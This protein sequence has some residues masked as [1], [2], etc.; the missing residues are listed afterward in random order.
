MSKTLYQEFLVVGI[1]PETDAAAYAEQQGMRI[2]H[3]IAKHIAIAALS[4]GRV[5]P[6]FN[7]TAAVYAP[8]DDRSI[9]V[10]SYEPEHLAAIMRWRQA[11]RTQ[12]IG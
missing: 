4:E 1:T 8:D 12:G 2:K 10:H 7:A 11:Q 3:P 6:L 9:T 5:A